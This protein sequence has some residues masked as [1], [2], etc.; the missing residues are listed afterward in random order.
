MT[1]L[2][3][4]TASLLVVHEIDS[5]YWREWELFGLPGGVE[6]FLAIHLPLA[7]LLLWGQGQVAA[8]TRAGLWVSVAAGMAGVATGV[9]HGTFLARGAAQFRSAGS[10]GL[11]AA[12]TASGL[13]LLASAATSPRPTQPAS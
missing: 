13:A 3:P 1:R 8:R 9:I 7:L 11:I 2:Y 12:T 6:L 10:L 5:A 4:L